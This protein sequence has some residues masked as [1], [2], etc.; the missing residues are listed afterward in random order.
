MDKLDV[1]FDLQKKLNEDI[2]ERRGLQE[3]SSQEWMQK[4]V[5]AIISEL[6]EFLDEINFKWWKNPKE[7]DFDSVHEEL[8][9]ILHFYISI[10]IHAG[11]SADDLYR[12]YLKKNQENID[13]QYGRSAK[14][15]YD[16]K[17]V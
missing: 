10:C 5:L 8:I 12:V 16:I 2:V 6:G 15:G 13:R 14:K 17:E 9:D 3:I 1:I 7:L 11:M 4:N